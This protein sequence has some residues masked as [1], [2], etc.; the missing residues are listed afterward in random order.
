MIFSMEFQGLG[1]RHLQPFDDSIEVFSI[2]YPHYNNGFIMYPVEDSKI[3]RPN[4]VE[5][6]FESF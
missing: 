2:D 3:S 1:L 6:R 4:P 5:R